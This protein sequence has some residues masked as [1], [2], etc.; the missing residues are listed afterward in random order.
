MLCSK[1]GRNQPS[2]SGEKVENVKS[3]QTYRQTDR[4]MPDKKWSDVLTW[5]FSSGDLKKRLKKK[6]ARKHKRSPE[7]NT[8]SQRTVII[9]IANEYKI[10][11]NDHK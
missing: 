6:E 3:L 9:K 5:A 8:T 2:G 7:Y 10:I 1:F 4:Q 11:W